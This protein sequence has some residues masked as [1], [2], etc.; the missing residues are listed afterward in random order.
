[1]KTS[2]SQVVH[3]IPASAVLLIVLLVSVMCVQ[4]AAGRYLPTRS[5]NSRRDR[6][7]DILR[8]VCF[9]LSELPFLS[10]RHSSSS[11][12]KVL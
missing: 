12:F 3:K 11:V 4:V 1:M 8:M 10:C 7:K 6:I 2:G 9:A 5:D